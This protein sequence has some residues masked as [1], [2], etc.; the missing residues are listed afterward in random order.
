LKRWN[1][2]P[3]PSTSSIGGMRHTPP[4]VS[5]TSTS[6]VMQTDPTSSDSGMTKKSLPWI[7]A[8]SMKRRAQ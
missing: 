8:N 1:W 6:C 3:L 2:P 7:S 4:N 5:T